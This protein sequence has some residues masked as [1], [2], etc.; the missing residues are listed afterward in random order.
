MKKEYKI[1]YESDFSGLKGK[2]ERIV[3]PKSADE[4]ASAIKTSQADVVPRG[5]GVSSVGGAVPNNSII[6]DMRKMNKVT[7]FDAKFRSVWAEAGVSI[8]ELNEKLKAVGFEFPVYDSFKALRSVGGM[9]ALNLSGDRFRYGS[10]KDWVEGIEIVNG[11]GEIVKISKADLMDVCG[12][13]GITGVIVNAKLK[14][15]PIIKRSISIFQS[16]NIDEILSMARRLKLDKEVVMLKFYSKK[17]SKLL[18]LPEKYNL[19][20]EFDSDRGKIK[21]NGYDKIMKTKDREDFVLYSQGYYHCIDS[22]MFFDNIKDFVNFAEQNGMPYY[23]GLGS[24]IICAFYKDN[25]DC[26]KEKLMNFLSKIKVKFVRHGYGLKRKNLIE[27]NEKKILQ[28]VKMRYDPFEKINRNKVIDTGQKQ[29]APS[30]IKISDSFNEFNDFKAQSVANANDF[31]SVSANP[32]QTRDFSRGYKSEGDFREKKDIRRYVGFETR[33]RG[34]REG[35]SLSAA[36]LVEE[37]ESPFKEMEIEGIQKE[38][39]EDVVMNFPDDEIKKRVLDY[40]QTF[41]SELLNEK[42]Q[43]VESFAKQVPREIVKK[44]ESRDKDELKNALDKVGLG[45]GFT[46]LENEEVENDD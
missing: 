39:K 34:F 35:E 38:V 36:K 19:L 10:A 3:F 30:E 25:E 14:I 12:M 29:T 22:K 31:N 4:V 1:C 41:N 21:D 26:K 23:G 2:A 5:F 33:N 9:I 7:N 42:K 17:V 43:K 40:E 15:I 11:R 20:I 28:R 6:L 24:G 16:D 46:A 27:P 18:N 45:V 8:K 37:I 44:K 32:E 13:E